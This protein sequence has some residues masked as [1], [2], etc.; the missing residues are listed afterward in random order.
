MFM[1]KVA[2]ADLKKN[3][4]IVVAT[5]NLG[6]VKEIKAIL[7]PLFP[8]R[9]FVALAE[10]ALDDYIEPE[11]NG[12]TFADNALIKAEYAQKKLGLTAIADDS[13]LCVDALDGAPGIFSARW[14][15]AHGDDRANNLKLLEELEKVGALD[16]SQRRAHFVSSVALVFDDGSVLQAEGVCNGVIAPEEKGENGFGYDPIFLA[17]A[18]GGDTTTAQVSAEEKNAISHRSQALKKLAKKLETVLLQ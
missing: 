6:K 16:K 9:D 15:G 3:K 17:D 13:G 14:A 12:K 18:L 8:N 7:G 1:N 4:S 10:I 5:G 11:E 2:L